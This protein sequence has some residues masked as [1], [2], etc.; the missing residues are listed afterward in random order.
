MGLLDYLSRVFYRKV[1][2]ERGSGSC[3]DFGGDMFRALRRE[4]L[5]RH[6]EGVRKDLAYLATRR[7]NG[8]G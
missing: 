6:L 3:E 8:F 4:K 2:G 5:G 7:A 1:D